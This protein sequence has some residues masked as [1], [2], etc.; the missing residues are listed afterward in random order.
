MSLFFHGKKQIV[1]LLFL[2]SL[3]SSFIFRFLFTG[4]CSS[5]AW[6]GRQA[7]KAYANTLASS[8]MS[9]KSWSWKTLQ[10]A[11]PGTLLVFSCCVQNPL[12]DATETR[13][14]GFSLPLIVGDAN[15]V[16]SFDTKSF[17]K[18]FSSNLATVWC[19]PL[20]FQRVHFLSGA[21]I[22][23][24]IFIKKKLLSSTLFLTGHR[25]CQL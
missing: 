6:A 14:K 11:V 21:F 2:F 25:W 22:I 13:L 3:Y 1:I 8:A 4:K 15:G 18:I 7:P 12:D 20:A 17:R 24:I 16:A 19:D 23:M 10:L 5:A 9:R